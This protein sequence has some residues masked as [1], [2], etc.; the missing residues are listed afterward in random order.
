MTLVRGKN[1]AIE[2]FFTEVGGHLADLP[3]CCTARASAVTA[4]ESMELFSQGL[5]L[6]AMRVGCE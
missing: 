4:R 1:R 3:V 6:F 2:Q 5:L